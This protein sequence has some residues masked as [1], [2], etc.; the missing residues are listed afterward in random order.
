MKITYHLKR[1]KTKNPNFSKSAKLDTNILENSFDN[2]EEKF[3]WPNAGFAYKNALLSTTVAPTS[4]EYIDSN[5]LNLIEE[6]SNIRYY[7]TPNAAT[8]ILRRVDRQGRTL[9]GPL[10]KGLELLSKKDK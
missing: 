9:F 3:K 7:L 5:L 2:H 6:T 4:S 10:R 8:G 1:L